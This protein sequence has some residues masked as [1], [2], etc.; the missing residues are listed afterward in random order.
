MNW[1]DDETNIMTQPSRDMPESESEDDNY[2][3]HIIMKVPQYNLIEV[4]NDKIQNKKKKEKNQKKNILTDM[5]KKQENNVRK[6]N[7]RL[8]P[9]DKYKK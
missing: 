3:Q 8:P 9:P 7:P 1:S 2:M 4:S 6:F 5:F